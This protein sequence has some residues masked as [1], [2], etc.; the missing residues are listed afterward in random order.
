MPAGRPLSYTKEK[1]NEI[2][3]WIASGKSLRSYCAIEGNPEQKTVL[4]WVIRMEK[5]RQQY[6]EAREMQAEI[7]ADEITDIADDSSQDR[8][9]IDREGRE[10]EIV[11]HDHINR[12]RLRVD[13]R[14][15]L[16]S[17]LLP[18]KY[19][20]MQQVKLS[21]PEGGP[22]EVRSLTDEQL[23]S[24]L[25]LILSRIERIGISFAPGGC[26]DHRNGA[27]EIEA[28]NLLDVPGGGESET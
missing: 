4:R 25:G 11:D 19:G 27:Q 16:L 20:D 2:C 12:S 9:V 28:Q 23:A 18:K 6:A 5:F 1:G 8:T 13:S 15:W 7:W 14:K 3:E 17:K 22:I 10:I 24:K 26:A 21:N